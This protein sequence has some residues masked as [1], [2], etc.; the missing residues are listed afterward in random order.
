MGNQPEQPTSSDPGLRGEMQ[1]PLTLQDI[2]EEM[3]K[4]HASLDFLNNR[5]PPDMVKFVENFSSFLVDDS[6]VP[7]DEKEFSWK[8]MVRDWSHI[9][10]RQDENFQDMA[11]K[12]EFA[13]ALINSYASPHIPENLR[14][15]LIE[16]FKK[17]ANLRTTQFWEKEEN[18]TG[19]A[20]FLK[21]VGSALEQLRNITY[22]DSYMAELGLK[23]SPEE[24]AKWNDAEEKM[25]TMHATVEGKLVGDI[26]DDFNTAYTAL[27]V[28]AQFVPIAFAKQKSSR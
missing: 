26:L 16:S 9:G 6:K 3:G 23:P 7:D 8:T 1:Y 10:S 15:K 21:K 25:K 28:T 27:N 19:Y 20:N 12:K 24:R 4:R 18:I 5:R 11:W 2:K 22:G 13:F 14:P 17:P